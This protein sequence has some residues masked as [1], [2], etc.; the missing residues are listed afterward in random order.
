MV[1]NYLP[2]WKT[3]NINEIHVGKYTS[4]M[5]GFREML[6]HLEPKKPAEKPCLPLPFYRIHLQFDQAF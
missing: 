1:N 2:R 6:F 3:I 4:P 5:D